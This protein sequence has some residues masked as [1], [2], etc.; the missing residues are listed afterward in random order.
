MLSLQVRGGSFLKVLL[1]GGVFSVATVFA[2]SGEKLDPGLIKKGAGIFSQNCS[3]CHGPRMQ[4]PQGAFDLRTFPPDQKPRFLNSVTKGKNQM[5][6]W[7]GLLSADDIES[8]WA[9]VIAGEKP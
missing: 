2:K 3:P 5:P 9:Y 8:L 7:G 1:V 4:D 6:P